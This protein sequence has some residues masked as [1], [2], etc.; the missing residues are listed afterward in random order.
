[1]T[2][3]NKENTLKRS[4]KFKFKPNQKKKLKKTKFLKHKKRKR[5]M[6]VEFNN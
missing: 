4:Q 3:S 5:Q 1:M 2:K 6:N